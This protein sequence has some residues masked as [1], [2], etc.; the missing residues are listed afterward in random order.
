MQKNW[1][2]F[3]IQYKK[4]KLDLVMKICIETPTALVLNYNTELEL[5]YIT[6]RH[7]SDKCYQVYIVGINIFNHNKCYDEKYTARTQNAIAEILY[8][9]FKSN[10][11]YELNKNYKRDKK[12]LYREVIERVNEERAK[13]AN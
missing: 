12:N 11:F 4:L 2:T 9:R 5:M 13:G 3:L 8:D 6:I 10:V 7:T 1:K